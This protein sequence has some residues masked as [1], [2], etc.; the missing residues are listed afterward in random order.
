M[1]YYLL[2]RDFSRA[3]LGEAVWMVYIM[4]FAILLICIFQYVYRH[5]PRTL[6]VA[7]EGRPTGQPCD[8][9]WGFPWGA[10]KSTIESQFGLTLMQR[11]VGGSNREYHY[12]RA[13]GLKLSL[14]TISSESVELV[15]SG[16]SLWSGRLV[17]VNIS[18]I[19]DKSPTRVE[20]EDSC[21]QLVAFLDDRFGQ[22]VESA[23]HY[24]SWT[25]TVAG[26]VIEL[27]PAMADDLD[28]HFSAGHLSVC[29]DSWR[30]R[31]LF[32]P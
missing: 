5:I 22:H 31:H 8:P 10:R 16:S 24:K 13:N 25:W 12:Y 29:A 27:T 18:H 9:F 21:S 26:N 30:K 1:A 20:H 4:A 11:G 17:T 15:F 23:G 32:W 2:A 3:D 28:E 7:I 19:P 6:A 14:G